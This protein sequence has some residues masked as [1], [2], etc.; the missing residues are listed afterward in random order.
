MKHLL[1]QLFHFQKIKINYSINNGKNIF[2]YKFF[3]FDKSVEWE[4]QVRSSF[5]KSIIIKL[6]RR[7]Y[8]QKNNFTD[9]SSFLVRHFHLYTSGVHRDALRF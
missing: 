8:V 1:D 2:F 9:L 3:F 7:P 6:E 4:D 5:I